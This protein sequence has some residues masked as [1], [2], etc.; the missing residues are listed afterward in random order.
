MAVINKRAAFGVVLLGSVWVGMW[1]LLRIVT[2]PAALET[3]NQLV[4]WARETYW[5]YE[6]EQRLPDSLA[7]IPKREGYCWS[8]EDGWGNRIAYSVEGERVSFKSLGRDRKPGGE[9]DDKDLEVS[10]CPAE[11]SDFMSFIRAAGEQVG[12]RGR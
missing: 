6:R 5:Y 2:I 8:L 9:G 11:Y 1:Q 7:A 10:V 12:F 3:K 4:F